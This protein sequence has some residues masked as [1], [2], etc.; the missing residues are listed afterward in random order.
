MNRTLRAYVR[1]NCEDLAASPH[2]LE[3]IYEITFRSN[4]QAVM[5]EYVEHYVTCQKTYAQVQAMA[6][7]VSAG[8]YRAIGATHGYVGL[9]MENSVGWIAAFW[10]IL[11]SGNKPYLVN[12]RHPKALSD[13]ILAHLDIRW[14][15]SDK[16]TALRAETLLLD[17]LLSTPAEPLPQVF[18]NEL[19]LSTSATTL[20]ETVCFYTGENLTSQ[21]LDARQI[22]LDCDRMASFYHGRLKQLAFLPFYHIFGLFAVYLWFSFFGRSF[23]FLPDYSPETILRTVREF[24]VTH[25]FAV[26]LLW[27][28]LADQV[29]RQARR[30]GKE[31]TLDRGLKLC[32]ALQNLWPGPGLWLSRRLMG[33]VTRQVFGPSVQFCISGGSCLRQDAL[34]LVGGL[35]YPLY[36]GYGMSETGITSVELRSRPKYRNRNAIGRPLASVR[37]RIGEG[38]T[39]EI[40]GASRST[41]LMVNGLRRPTPDWLD[42]G[43]VAQCQNGDYYVR[44]RLGD[45]VIGENGENI[46]PDLLEHHFSLPGCRELCILGL[47][48]DGRETLTLVARVSPYLPAPGLARLVDAAYAQ[49]SRLPSA[50]QVQKFY[51][52]HDPLA[53]ETAVKV[54][55]SWLR[56]AVQT[57]AVT[58][59]P[60]VRPETDDTAP[61]LNPALAEKVRALAAA[62]M[63]LDPAR[64]G[65]DDHFTQDLGCSSLQYFSLLTRLKETFDL[66]PEAAAGCYTLR[67]VCACLEKELME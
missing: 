51:L 6:E 9:E 52:T 11:R 4:A 53:P 67:Q 31:R 1:K 22:L 33:R 49:N 16:P 54:G 56:R 57:G 63:G 42:S 32:T 50:Q 29:R 55:R 3:D 47:E 64:V 17:D 39:L 58:L 41:A 66:P 60:F 12:C 59:L 8:I 26:P 14:V 48:E 43:D 7:S 28:T 65:D 40:A 27:H 25:I 13:K 10:G 15:V 23:V 19:A 35:G 5:A 37:Y 20:G 44:G 21:I 36:N 46:D 61:A 38:G 2:R 62:A 24:E 34:Y 30:Q 45:R 18:E